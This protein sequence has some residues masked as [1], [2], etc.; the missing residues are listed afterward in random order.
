MKNPDRLYD[1]LPAI[2]RQ[3]DAEQGYPLRALLRVISREVDIVE[4]DIRQLHENWFIETCEDWVVPYIA[5]LIGYRPVHDAGEPGDPRQPASAARNRILVPRREVAQTIG[6]RRRKGTLALLELLANDVAGWPAR[7]VE[8]YRRLGWMQHLNHQRPDRA[9]T[10]DLREGD[11]LDRIDGPFDASTHTV[12]VR[13]INSRRTPG[14]YNLPE[15]GTFVW[16][17]RA[18]SVT[19]SPACCLETQRHCFTFSVLGNDSPLFSPGHPEASPTAIA[20]ELNVPTSI[21]R[22]AFARQVNRTAFHASPEYYGQGRSLAIWARDW[23]T[24]GAQQPIPANLVVPADLSGWRY[25][26]PVGK[27]AVD[28]RLGRIAFPP[29][30]AP[31]AGVRVSYHYGFGGELGGGEYHRV[32]S[33]PEGALR[34]QVGQGAEFASIGD[35]LARWSAEKQLRRTKDSPGPAPLAVVIEIVDSQAYTERVSLKL[36]PGESLQ[37]RA[38]DRTRPILRL[39]DYDASQADALRVSG[40]QGSRLTLDGLLL[41]GRGIEVGAPEEGVPGD[42]CDLTIRHCTLVPGWGIHCDCGPKHPGEPS[43]ELNTTASIRIRHSILG[44]IRVVNDEVRTD[45]LRLE[46]TDSIWDGLDDAAAVLGGPEGELGHVALTIR[47]TTVFG[48]V[49]AHQILLA[50]NSI[51]TGLVRVARRQPGCMRFCY[52]PPGSRTPRRY[53]CQPD[54]VNQ[55]VAELVR[56][57]ELPATELDRAQSLEQARVRP[58]FLSS[59]YGTPDY[60]RL[61]E[62]CGGEIQRGADDESELGAFHDLYQPQRRANLRARLDE[63]TPAGS[64]AGIIHAS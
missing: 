54:L 33:E 11:V 20:G 50:E 14:R 40:G 53:A 32:S 63:F 43:L 48:E 19:E 61:A 55:A 29:R 46:I 10:A 25:H 7:A 41:V 57:G 59:R 1:L 22:R 2:H 4:D 42:L 36:E 56:T 51:F 27:V 60:A 16:R 37:L 52:A 13:R 34:L 26:T 3:R 64:D 12:D 17:L 38:A 49:R 9:R 15:V 28:P 62:A 35:A 23:P 44:A 31:A 8:F 24:K 6:F 39:L 30:H 18:Y 47:R 21:R 58:Q 5:D 45:P